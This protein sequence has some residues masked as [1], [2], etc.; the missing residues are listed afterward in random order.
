MNREV[1]IGRNDDCPCGSVFN[2]KR[3]K[4]KKCYGCPNSVC[5]LFLRDEKQ[6]VVRDHEKRDKE[7]FAFFTDMAEEFKQVFMYDPIPKIPTRIAFITLFSLIDTLA[8]FWSE[9]TNNHGKPKERFNVWVD[10]FIFTNIN[11]EYRQ[12]E[13]LSYV[14]M[15]QLYEF[16]SSLVHFM[17]L[18][19]QSKYKYRISLIENKNEKF[20]DS[21]LARA[22]ASNNIL[23]LEPKKFF[24]VILEGAVNMF[25]E[26][27]EGLGGA[28]INSEKGQEYI[29]GIQR[30]HKKIKTDGAVKISFS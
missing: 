25:K 12:Y 14:D 15:N 9:Y 11:Q 28:D 27:G 20:D 23:I 30:L 8:N 29:Q 18:A 17:G 6:K 10:K 16:R 4:Y 22:L 24:K 26:I 13:Q 1:K 19:S 5:P 2:G 7:V 3:L 21:V